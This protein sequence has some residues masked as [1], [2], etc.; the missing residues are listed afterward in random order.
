MPPLG[1]ARLA[2]W[3]G[4]GFRVEKRNLLRGGDDVPDCY[5]NIQLSNSA[6]WKTSVIKD[7]V[8][9]VWGKDEQCDFLLFHHDQVVQVQAWD[10]NRGRTPD[11]E[12]SLQ[13]MLVMS[14]SLHGGDALYEFGRTARVNGT[15][16]TDHWTATVA[17]QPGTNYFYAQSVDTVGRRSGFA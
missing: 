2:L 9:P 3:R 12:R 7:S 17:L 1:V 13:G 15:N 16:G 6:V 14:R 4:R 5:C 8:A 10:A 11:L